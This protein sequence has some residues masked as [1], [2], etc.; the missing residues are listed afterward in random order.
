MGVALFL[1]PPK[2]FE[3]PHDSVVRQ[4]LFEEFEK[5]NLITSDYKNWYNFHQFFFLSDL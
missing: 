4:F 1:K 3:L 2:L 5:R